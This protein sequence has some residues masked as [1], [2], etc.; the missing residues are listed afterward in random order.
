[1]KILIIGGTGTIGSGIIKAL[2]KDSN[3]IIDVVSRNKH[4]DFSGNLRHIQG[5]AK[6][7]GFISGVVQAG[8]YDAIV[9]LMIW[10][11][12]EFLERMSLFM[13]NTG[14]YIAASTSTVYWDTEKPITEETARIFDVCNDVE[15]KNSHEYRIEKS[16]IEDNINES[17]YSNWTITR[18][19]LT[20]GGKK[21]P[22][23]VYPKEIWLYRALH[24][25]TV[26]VA[27]EIMSKHVALTSG[28]EVGEKVK[29]I[30]CNEKTY[31]QIINVVSDE[32]FAA[33][34][35]ERLN[36]VVNFFERER[37]VVLGE[38][39]E[40]LLATLVEFFLQIRTRP[41]AIFNFAFKQSFKFVRVNV[42]RHE[43]SNGY[44]VGFVFH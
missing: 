20:Y 30:I 8:V 4:E 11:E 44:A 38:L 5:D 36:R 43:C 25:R 18:Y 17:D 10:S 3:N 15:L 33:A 19:S 40:C 27:E 31:R 39:F 14:H 22:L 28:D 35:F 23:C 24:G 32:H 2:Q 16:R 26:L 9:D 21:I 29:K 6:D 34:I 42:R 12:Q 7:Y 13:E 37:V 1:M 41:L